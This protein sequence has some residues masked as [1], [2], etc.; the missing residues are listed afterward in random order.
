MSV[1]PGTW[2]DG[3][4]NLPQ[5][6]R[7]VV[8]AGTARVQ[9][10]AHQFG[11]VPL[12]QLAVSSRLGDTPRHIRLPDI[13]GVF[14][15]R[16]NDAVDRLLPDR[17]SALLHRMESRLRWVLIAI[18]V[19]AVAGYLFVSKGIPVV[20]EHLA[21]ALP[22]EV[23]S[24]IGKGTLKLLDDRLFEPT[25]LD[26]RRQAELRARFAPLTSGTELPVEVLFRNADATLGANALALPSG[27]IV[28]TDELV[29]LAEDDRELMAVLAH[30][31]AHVEGRHGLRQTL[32]HSLLSAAAVV[33]FGDISS[34]SSIAAAL[35]M[36]LTELGY[37]RE[38]EA[39]ADRRGVAMMREHGI[40][41][42]HFAAILRRLE[43]AACGEE[44]CSDAIPEYLLTHPPTEHRIEALDA[45]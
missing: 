7:L 25:L 29:Q 39:E 43:Q 9:L 35:P 19:V 28:F 11:P 21:H 30:E 38:M 33:V 34:V 31:I 3:Q 6:A 23:N 44:P 37:T 20:S 10:P 13:S 45:F 14:E 17:S 16:D 42:R 26:E 8:A 41:T 2:F 15:T 40:D 12:D 4:S 5:E 32:Q 1:I 24:Q 22:E 36:V 18:V 27:A